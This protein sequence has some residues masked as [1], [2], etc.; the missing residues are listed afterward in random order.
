MVQDS[1]YNLI[2]LIVYDRTSDSIIGQKSTGF[3]DEFDWCSMDMSGS[4]CIVGYGSIDYVQVFPP[5]LSASMDLPEGSNAH[6]D[7]ALTAGG[8][9]VFVYQNTA[10]DYISMADLN[11]GAET[12]LIPIPFDVNTDIGLHFSGNC[13]ET[14]GWV[15]VSTYGSFN[16][17]EGESHSWMDCQLFMLELKSNPR[18]W[19]IAHTQSYTSQGYTGEKNYFAEA[20]AAINTSGTRVYW[21][22]NWRDYTMDYTDTYVV[23]LE[24]NWVT[25]MPSGN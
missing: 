3:P 21:G 2:S 12:Q 19:R 7:L 23:E 20:F 4:H 14:P 24:A 22:S 5:D 16:P 6:G 25:E 8:E 13:D 9:D 17:P 1:S 11:T 15:L 18:I 10:T